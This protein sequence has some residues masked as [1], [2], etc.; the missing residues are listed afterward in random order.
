MDL[1][2]S[3]SSWHYKL[4]RLLYGRW[5]RDPKNLCPYFWKTIV[6]GVIFIVPLAIICTPAKI[7]NKLFNKSW[8]EN[9]A[10]DEGYISPFL[11]YSIGIDLGL[12]IS[13]S[14][15]GIWFTTF[16]K[17]K[18]TVVQMLGM[19]GYIILAI[20]L[21]FWL[22]SKWLDY[23]ELKRMHKWRSGSVSKEAAPNI[24]IEAVK[25]WYKK[26][27]PMITWEENKPI[28]EIQNSQNGEE[29]QGLH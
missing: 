29:K 3:K 2:F 15:V 19:V 25:A 4:H 16:V 28:V 8:Q 12:L 5:A 1:K 7:V 21:F 23:K 26:Y 20:I 6:V 11:L 10:E 9:V 27:C 17:D 14:M 18:I 24:A 22:R 13:Y